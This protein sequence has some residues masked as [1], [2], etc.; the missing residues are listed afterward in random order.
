MTADTTQEL[1]QKSLFAGERRFV[2]K[3]DRYLFIDETAVGRQ[4]SY[5]LDV[6]ALDGKP[7]FRLIVAWRWLLAAALTLAI[8]FPVLG[9]LLP[10]VDPEGNYALP[11]I[12]VFALTAFIFILL[13]FASSYRETVFRSRHGHWP[14][15]R[16]LHDRPDST[17][18]RAFV[19]AITDACQT[20][21]DRAGLSRQQLLAGEIKTLRRLSRK[22]VLSND[23]Y[24]RLRGRLMKMTDEG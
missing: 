2:L 24:E 22:G 5:E 15:V 12:I 11:V 8:E 16:L 9:H 4:R 6:L 20:A 21:T 3:N 17:R 23:D 14:L 19:Q 13:A 7:R 18:F 1:A 10:Q